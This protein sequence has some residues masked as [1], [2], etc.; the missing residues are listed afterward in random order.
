MKKFLTAI[1][2]SALS[3]S[4]LSNVQ[5]LNV[6]DGIFKDSL[7]KTSPKADFNSCRLW[8]ADGYDYDAEIIRCKKGK[9]FTLFWEGTEGATVSTYV[10][11]GNKALVS[12]TRIG[13]EEWVQKGIN[14]GMLAEIPVK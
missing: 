14:I 3:F 9:Q 5:S 10:K 7:G 1:T 8:T 11:K 4:A 6:G 13:L 2:L 12:Q